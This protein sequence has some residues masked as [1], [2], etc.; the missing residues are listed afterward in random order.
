MCLVLLFSVVWGLLETNE[1]F[2]G[3]IIEEGLYA[4]TYIHVRRNNV[5][6]LLNFEYILS[7]NI[8]RYRQ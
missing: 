5:F 8:K 7:I 6:F 4:N 1:M 3:Y 2:L